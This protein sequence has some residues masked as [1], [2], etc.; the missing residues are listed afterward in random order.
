MFELSAIKPGDIGNGINLI[1]LG[2][3]GKVP[4]YWKSLAYLTNLIGFDPNEKECDRLNNKNSA[5]LSQRFLP[6]AIAGDNESYTLYKTSSPYCWSLLQPDLSW[7]RR[8]TYS[9]LFEIQGKEE[10]NALTLADIDEL[11]NIDI[12]AIKIDTQGLELPIL[13]ASRDILHNCIFVETETGFTECY[14][15]E[16]TFDQIANYMRSMG[17][18]LFDINTNHR[19]PRKNSLSERAVNEQILWCE[20]IWLR[21]FCKEEINKKINITREKALKAL[22][23]YANHGCYAF[24]YEMAGR[25]KKLGLL[26]TEEYNA[27]GSG[28]SSWILHNK[29][30]LSVMK[31][32]MLRLTLSFIPRR[33]Y[34]VISTQLQQ[35]RNTRHPL[36]CLLGK[37][38]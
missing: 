2:A 5:F 23:I 17:F 8:F 22:C 28:T 32:N 15:G 30:G 21:D 34:N 3:S 31:K 20:A 19:V 38:R 7:L 6:Y 36:S 13:K 14:I 10:I 24:G 26:S 16:T 12:D 9:D 33:Y 25:F 35:L 18:D 11:T 4:S 37:R 27:L 1:D 29:M